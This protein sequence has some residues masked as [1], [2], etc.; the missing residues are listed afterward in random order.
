MSMKAA[1]LTYNPNWFTN[2]L[3]GREPATQSGPTQDSALYG[4]R[5]PQREAQ[6]EERDF[7]YVQHNQNFGKTS[8]T[9][10]FHYLEGPGLLI[11]ISSK[12][13]GN[14]AVGE[15]PQL[16]LR[17]V[18]T[19]DRELLIGSFEAYTGYFETHPPAPSFPRFLT[20][21]GSKTINPLQHPQS[22]EH[23]RSTGRKAES[24][25][26]GRRVNE[27]W[28]SQ[29]AAT[30]SA[31]P[32]D[33][34]NCGI[35][36]NNKI[37]PKLRLPPFPS[38][39]NLNNEPGAETVPKSRR[40][41][42][43][44]RI[45]WEA[46]EEIAEPLSLIFMSSLSTGI[47]LEDWRIANVVPLFKKGGRDSPGMHCSKMSRLQQQV[48]AEHLDFK[49]SKGCPK[50]THSKFPSIVFQLFRVF[51]PSVPIV[52][53]LSQVNCTARSTDYYWVHYS[54]RSFSSTL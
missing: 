26:R 16:T 31:E 37:H 25:V 8:Q 5:E 6:G 9:L 2:I 15:A 27:G 17:S 36:T 11:L 22:T 44:P 48:P 53:H 51:L 49:F 43:Y 4:R 10:N 50:L 30:P 42:I 3:Q 1:G 41:G 21:C 19:R 40:D 32:G 28:G 52:H 24:A 35:T 38:G 47:V 33:N 7:I 29:V 23:A 20:R 18:E 13:A 46:S 54:L 39:P 45:L 34:L 12:G 14:L